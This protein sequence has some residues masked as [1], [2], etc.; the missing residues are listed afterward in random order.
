MSAD[1]M[2]H[3]ERIKAAIDFKEPDR[4]PMFDSMTWSVNMAGKNLGLIG[5]K[6]KDVSFPKWIHNPDIFVESQI[7]ALD[8]FDHDFVHSRMSS[9]ILTE[10]MGCREEEPYWDVPATINTAINRVEDWKTLK[11]PN[12]D[13]DGKIPTQLTAI[14]MLDKELHEKRGDDVFI[15]GFVRGAFTLAVIVLGVERFMFSMID[16]PDETR[17]L[18]DFCNDVSIECI[19]AQIDAG[20]DHIY[21][22]DPR[23][24]AALISAKFYHDFAL[25]A[26]Q[27]QSA[28]IR[29]YKDKYAH[30]Y[31]ICGDTR[32][33]WDD[34]AKIG[35]SYV[36]LDY[37]INL[38]EAKENIGKKTAIAGNMS[39]AGTLLLGTPGMV[40]EEGK[41]M[42]R[43]AA[44]GGGY[45]YWAGC[46]LPI[47]C[48]IENVDKFFEVPKVYG[49]YPIEI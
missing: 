47:D 32:A 15:T 7:K 48:P 6:V 3:A 43:D 8:R 11:F 26:A 40:E 21:T 20:A 42:I 14:R 24:S 2:S 37:M 12:M 1:D 27:K 29:K 30:H 18:I 13:K 9:H 22:P 41:Q 45:I 4:V 46:D 5:Q 10:A 16:K 49:K 23:A 19:K 31:H 38:K 34:L 36:S 35:A 39:P 25:P 44:V 17:E 33:R 28:A